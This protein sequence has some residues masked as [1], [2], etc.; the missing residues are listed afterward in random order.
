[1]AARRIS[2]PVIFIRSPFGDG[3]IRSPF[4]DGFIR[5]RSGDGFI[6]SRSGDGFIRSPFGDG[7]SLL[8]TETVF[9]CA[10]GAA[11]LSRR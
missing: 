5:S 11:E 10:R 3:F 8:F 2:A 6:R 1:M 9:R 7:S 4:G